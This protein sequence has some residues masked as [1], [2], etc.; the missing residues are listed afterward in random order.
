ME[1][2]LWAVKKCQ[3]F[4]SERLKGFQDDF[5]DCL[6]FQ[7]SRGRAGT[8]IGAHEVLQRMVVSSSFVHMSSQRALAGLFSSIA[9]SARKLFKGL[10]VV[11]AIFSF[12]C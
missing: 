9:R 7:T 5:G 11:A 6:V 1:L 4:F 8:W 3:R 12:R 2:R 10:E